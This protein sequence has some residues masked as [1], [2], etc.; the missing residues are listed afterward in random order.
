MK[1]FFK[2]ITTVLFI[3]SVIFISCDVEEDESCNS[4]ACTEQFVTIT[5]FI[6]DQGQNPV[7]LD[8]FEVINLRNQ[9]NITIPLSSSGFLLVQQNGLYPLV[10]D[11]GI[12]GNQRQNLQF[13]GFINGIEVINENYTVEADCCHV[14]LVS[15]NLEL[16]LD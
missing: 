7:V 14:N 4:V 15:G 16:I 9:S 10:N 13:K 12:D 3:F 5:V 2:V 11:S 6:I 1:L 8:R